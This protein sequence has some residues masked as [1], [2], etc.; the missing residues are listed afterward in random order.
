MGTLG[1]AEALGMEKQIGSLEVGKKADL[2]L[3]S[4]SGSH[5]RPINKI[6]NSL[7]YCANARDV[8][9]V[10]CDGR[11][12]MENHRILTLDEEAWVAGAVEYAY[13]RFTQAGIE[14]PRYYCLPIG[15]PWG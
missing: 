6:E 15:P 12:V 10:I 3:V 4:L 13:Q 2:I 8:E 9:T 11:L 1:G 5:M 14:L 7:V